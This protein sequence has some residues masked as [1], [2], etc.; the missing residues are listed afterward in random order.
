MT[1]KLSWR[2][3]VSEDISKFVYTNSE[4]SAME[5]ERELTLDA[6]RLGLGA[7]LETSITLENTDHVTTGIQN[8]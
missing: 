3:N 8:S 2:F 4:E 1:Y 6:Y 7:Y 5:I